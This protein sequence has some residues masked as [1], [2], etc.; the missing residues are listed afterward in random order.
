[1]IPV[2]IHKNRSRAFVFLA[3]PTDTLEALASLATAAEGHVE[4]ARLFGAAEKLRRTT[5][6]VRWPLDQAAYAAEVTQ[7]RTVLGDEPVRHGLV[8][9]DG[10]VA[11]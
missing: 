5:G 1:M 3:D 6:Q 11:G 2:D 7:L 10:P 4:A 8:G 9:G